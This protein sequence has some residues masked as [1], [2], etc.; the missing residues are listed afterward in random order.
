MT[1]R[2]LYRFAAF[3]LAIQV[4]CPIVCRGQKIADS[5]SASDRLQFVVILARH[6]VRSPTGDPGRYDEYS[7]S[8]WPK[9][10][11]PPGYLTPHGF[12]LMKLFGAYDRAYLA[13]EGLLAPTGCV[14]ASYVSIVAD[15]DERTR[16]T[17]KALAA[18]MFPGCSVAV[19]ALAEHVPDPLFHSL[20]AGVGNPDRPLALAAVEGS[21]GGNANNLTEAYR[22]QLEEF[23]H[24]L[25]GC[26]RSPATNRERTS[27]LDAPVAQEQGKGDHASD[28]HGP[29]P[30]GSSMAESLL[31]EYADGKQGE[32]L[33]WGCLSEK[34]L[35]EI[36]QLHEAEAD[37]SDRS[38]AIARM[39]VSNLLEHILAAIEQSA[40][41]K[42]VRG[43]PG[44]P[45]DRVLFLVGHDTNI[46]SVAGLLGLHWIIDGRR[47]DTPP[48]GA[49]VFELRRSSNG[50]ST[51]RLY[52]TAQTLR[53]MRA[54]TPLTL[55]SPPERMSLFVPGCGR[56]DMSCT[57]DSLATTVQGVVDPSYVRMGP[58][59]S[60]VTAIS[61]RVK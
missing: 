39:N 59:D 60:A 14:D 25:A 30:I 54:A 33:G 10:E 21:F 50:V 49:L 43:A 5:K 19:Q 15:S 1:E 45:D 17:G 29:L 3:V 53:Q 16:E 11:V 35:S 7:A 41:G 42:T 56:S 18:G 58:A 51:V 40:S 26:G 55:A 46:A 24:V 12:A 9:W 20:H 22:P 31:L 6:G 27:I 23:D 57:L 2:V 36:M 32:E 52:Y 34:V 8:P 44:K 37:F 4:L 61:H 48:G 13:T 47:D 28:M 38:P